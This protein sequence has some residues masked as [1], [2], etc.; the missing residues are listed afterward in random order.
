MGGDLVSGIGL[1]KMPGLD[2]TAVKAI[3]GTWPGKLLGRL[4]ALMAAIV[5]VLAVVALVGNGLARV[6]VDA[7]PW[8]LAILVGGATLVIIAQL[9]NEGWAE[10]NRRMAASLA[11]KPIAM[12]TGYF[13]IGPFLDTDDDQ[14]RFDRADLA[15]QQALAWILG[16][17]APSLYLTGDSG[18]GKSSLLNAFVLPALRKEKWTLVTTRPSDDAEGAL[19]G[20]FTRSSRSQNPSPQPLRDSIEAAAR[21]A[22]KRLFLILDQFEEF[23]ILGTRERHQAF[24]A[25]ITDLTSNPIKKLTILIVLRSDYQ[26][27]LAEMG[28]PKLLQGE[29]FFQVGRFRQAAAR[30]FMKPLGL[31]DEALGKLLKSASELDDTPGMMRPITLN[32]LGFILSQGGPVASSVDAGNL[33]REYI[34]QAV[35]NPVVRNWARPVIEGLLTEEGTKRPRREVD[36]CDETKLGPGEVRAVLNALVDKALA[37]P[38]DRVQGVWEL[39]HDFIARAMGRYLGRRRRDVLRQTAFY[40]APAL[41]MIT[42][43]IVGGAAGWRNLGSLHVQAELAQLGIT[44]TS[45]DDGF[46]GESNSSFSGEN[47]ARIGFLLSRVPLTSLKL[48]VTH[49]VDDLT[50]LKQLTALRRLDLSGDGLVSDVG[51]LGGVTALTELDLSDTSVSDLTPLKSLTRLSS[52]DLSNDKDISDL[53]PLRSLIALTHLSLP[54]TSVSDLSP[55]KGLTGLTDLELM[56]TKV[57]DLSPVA[58]LVALTKLDLEYTLVSDLRPLMGITALTDLDVSGTDVSD[59]SPLKSLKALRTLYVYETHISNLSVV[60]GM[61]GLVVSR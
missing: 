53:A 40:S 12:P 37:R 27:A 23:I 52:L 49:E 36:L 28:L 2:P 44:L 20:A 1:P 15:H 5:A 11:R 34:T 19:A 47:F 30:G 4:A 6:G 22:E 54:N 43:L 7:P 25:L 24:A 58:R 17:T 26:T 50:P 51:P 31:K 32:V 42:V 55:L 14:K 60:D 41:L 61:K 8:L 46:V 33:V 45:T 35:E 9:I 13:R 21:R 38:L 56:S 16:S 39:S 3:R 29:N 10:H 18:S 59:F 48:T 57:S